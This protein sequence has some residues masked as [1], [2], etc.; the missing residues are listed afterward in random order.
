MARPTK[1]TEKIT[2]E[3]CS[4]LILGKS[5]REVCKADDMPVASTVFKWLSENEEFSEQYAHAKYESVHAIVDEIIDIA[6]EAKSE[7]VQ[8]ARLR[9]DTRKWVAA[10]LMPKKYG[11]RTKLVTDD[12]KGNDAS[13]NEKSAQTVDLSKLSDAALKEMRDQ[14]K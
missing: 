7:N 12:G 5:L 3:I 1:Y 4:R 9:T 11:D 8:V 13:I 2:A 10:K 6:D 14:F